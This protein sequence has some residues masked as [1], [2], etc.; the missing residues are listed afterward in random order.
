MRHERVEWTHGAFRF[1]HCQRKAD[2]YSFAV[3]AFEMATGV[4][5]DTTVDDPF[6]V[7]VL[8]EP[9]PLAPSPPGTDGT[10]AAAA[11]TAAVARDERERMR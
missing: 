11:A 6:T 5:P 7:T 4:L 3:T 2:I 1:Y 10:V 8:A 9:P